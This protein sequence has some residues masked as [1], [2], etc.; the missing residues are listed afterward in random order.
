[1]A[2][3]ELDGADVTASGLHG[4]RA[5]ALVDRATGRVGS[6]KS[7]KKFGE[8]LKWSAQF[9][10]PPQ[11]AGALPGVRLTH[12]KGVA[13]DSERAD[14]ES[15]LA[16]NFG[17]GVVLEAVAPEGLMLEFAA[18]TLG[19]KHIETTE[20]PV[21]GGAP[22]GTFFDFGAIHL[23]TTS[24]LRHLQ[25][26]RNDGDIP[27]QR[28]RPN[29]VID[30]GAENGFVEDAWVGRTLDIGN[31]TLRVSMPCPRCVMPTLARSDLP[32]DPTLLRLIAHMNTLDLG[33]IGRLPCAGVYADVT[34]AGRVAR[35]DRVTL[36]G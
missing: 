10:A 20:V 19:G 22:R 32:S 31:V 11:L 8:L 26:A 3:E 33:E 30:C 25:A 7:V 29:L 23:M 35:G 18:G 27:V 16:E 28:F 4:D 2:G 24:T 6:A 36:V 17:P 12:P 21:A 34:K 15:V 14:L 1:M 9:K 13:I 5:Y